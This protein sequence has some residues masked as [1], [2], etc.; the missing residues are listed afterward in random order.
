MNIEKENLED[1]K[2]K[3]TITVEAEQV[4]KA[5]QTAL[6][7]L[8]KDLEIEGFRKGKAPLKKVRQHVDQGKLNGK[9]INLLVPQA[10]MN[11]IKQEELKP[12]TNPKIEIKK[13]AEGNELVFEALICEM[14]KVD[15]GNWK[16]VVKKLASAPKIET[17]ATLTEAESKADQ[18]DTGKKE[19]LSAQDI[20]NAIRKKTKIKIPNMIIENEV[21]RMLSQLYDQLDSLGLSPE[22]YLDNRGKTKEELKDEYQKLATKTLEN[23]FIL[24]EIIKELGIQA[25][26]KEIQEAIDSIPDEK[27]K[28]EMDTPANRA[29]IKSVLKKNKAIEK[30]LEIARVKS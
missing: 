6:K 2:V 15:L 25:E 13:F 3:L 30:L 22:E 20:L 24:N 14:P 8:G 16:E 1:G 7:Q 12:A 17:A 10:Y 23:E 27:A 5:F 28:G 29:Y 19:E 11:A 4:K 21:T 18:E 26:E 9:V